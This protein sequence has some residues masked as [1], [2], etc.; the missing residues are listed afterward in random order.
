MG[1]ARRGCRSHYVAASDAGTLLVLSTGAG[2]VPSESR[3]GG[4]GVAA[5][6][7]LLR[8]RRDQSLTR[9]GTWHPVLLRARMMLV[10]DQRFAPGATRALQHGVSISI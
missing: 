10:L 8:I 1:S 6:R 9:S 4:R 7:L 2:H 5:L 3:A